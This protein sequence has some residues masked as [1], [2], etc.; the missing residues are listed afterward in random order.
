MVYN[1]SYQ[2]SLLV[3]LKSFNI[4]IKKYINVKTDCLGMDTKRKLN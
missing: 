2:L 4:N 3:L 1:V